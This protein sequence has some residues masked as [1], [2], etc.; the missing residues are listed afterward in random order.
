MP[1]ISLLS[2]LTRIRETAFLQASVV[3]LSSCSPTSGIAG[4]KPADI[5]NRVLVRLFEVQSCVTTDEEI[6]EVFRDLGIPVRA[7][8]KEMRAMIDAQEVIRAGYGYF[9]ED[10]GPF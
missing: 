9:L 3:A 7:G 5:E 8:M 2:A 4:S 1:S 6:E 10:D